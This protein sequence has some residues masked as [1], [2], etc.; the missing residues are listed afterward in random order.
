MIIS[1]RKHESFHVNN[2]RANGA[3]NT[4]YR[5]SKK[6]KKEEEEEEEEV[7]ITGET[8]QWNEIS[9]NRLTKVQG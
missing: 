3:D 5:E 1:K 6:K 8:M 4:I 2:R 9:R 7:S